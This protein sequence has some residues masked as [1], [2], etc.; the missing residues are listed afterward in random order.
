[1]IEKHSSTY[2]CGGKVQN[3][4]NNNGSQHYSNTIVDKVGIS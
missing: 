2:M 4:N 1:M 3:N